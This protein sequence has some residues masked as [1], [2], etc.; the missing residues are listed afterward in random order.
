MSPAWPGGTP[1]HTPWLMV[2]IGGHPLSWGGNFLNQAEALEEGG[3]QESQALGELVLE[4]INLR[5]PCP[6]LPNV[7]ESPRFNSSPSTYEVSLFYFL[8]LEMLWTFSEIRSE[9]KK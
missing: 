7:A 3:S 6:F 1:C 5:F 4:Y 2:A 8:S 9:K